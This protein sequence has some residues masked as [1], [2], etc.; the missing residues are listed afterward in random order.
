MNNEKLKNLLDEL[1][2]EYK[3]DNGAIFNE[4]GTIL[5]S[6]LHDKIDK[7]TLGITMATT[8]SAAETAMEETGSKLKKIIIQSDGSDWIIYKTSS[9]ILLGIAVKSDSKI[10][11]DLDKIIKRIEA[12]L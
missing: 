7:E 10:L 12:N 9:K 4:Y 2:K 5:A 8:F 6:F 3:I 1:K 11:G